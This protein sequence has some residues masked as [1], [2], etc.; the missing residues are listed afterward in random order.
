MAGNKFSPITFLKLSVKSTLDQQWC[1]CAACVVRVWCVCAA[2]R[3]F[4]SYI[5]I[6]TIRK[7]AKIHLGVFDDEFTGNT[8]CTTWLNQFPAILP[9]ANLIEFCCLF[10][11]HK[12]R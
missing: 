9:H 7:D 3:Q 6:K 8:L 4:A 5:S 2:R 1:V 12:M 10:V 11:Y